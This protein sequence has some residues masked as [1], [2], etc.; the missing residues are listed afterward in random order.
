MHAMPNAVLKRPI[1]SPINSNVADRLCATLAPIKTS[2]GKTQLEKKRVS[3]TS[4]R[5]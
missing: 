5:N 1:I 4:D 3:E 2:G